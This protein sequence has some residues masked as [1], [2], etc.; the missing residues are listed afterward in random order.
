MIVTLT[1]NPSLDRAMEVPRLERGAVLRSGRALVQAGGKGI[2]VVQALTANGVEAGAVLPIGGPEG[3]QLLDLLTARGIQVR[4]TP[5]AGTIRAN[6]S[7]VEPDGTVTKI[8]E[9]GPRLAADEVESLVAATVAAAAGASWVVGCGSLPDGAPVDLYARIVEQAHAAGVRAAVDTSGAPLLACLAAGPDLV[10]PNV[11]ELAA[12][13]GTDIDTIG[14]V[15]A[16]AEAL[17]ALGARAVLASLGADG[18][19]LVTG[20]GALHATCRVDQPV[21]AVGAGDAALAGY[22]SAPSP[23]EGLRAAVA[24]G[25]AAV[26]LP[27][28]A[29]PGPD[30]IDPTAVTQADPIDLDLQLTERNRTDDARLRVR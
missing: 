29:L 1:P 17:R 9:P 11:D 22:L 3:A 8:N 27:G 15:V 12:A 21:S 7:I 5:I 14:D 18:A 16:A 4:T 20:T 19:V 13:A 26:Q 24:F 2:N 6:I 25:A 23:E 10:K 28:S 30:D